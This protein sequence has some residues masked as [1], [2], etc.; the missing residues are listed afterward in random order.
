MLTSTKQ[1]QSSSAETAL[2]GPNQQPG[3][4]R[5]LVALCLLFPALLTAWYTLD[6]S[7]PF[8]DAADHVRVEFQYCDLLRHARPW[9]AHWLKEFLTVNYCYPPSVH[10]FNGALKAIFGSG[11]WVDALSLITF[12]CLLSFSSCATALLTL[13]SRKA[14][15]LTVTL[16]QAYPGVALLSHLKL[17]DYPHLA[18]Y[19]CAMASLLW[20]QRNPSWSRAVMCG[21]ALGIACT[22]KQIA[23]FFLFAPCLVVLVQQL[24]ARRLDQALQLSLSGL[25][26]VLFLAVWVLPNWDGING[27][28]HRNSGHLGDRTVIAAFGQNLAGYLNCAPGL[29][30]YPLLACA[31]LSLFTAK[32]DQLQ[33]LVLPATAALAGTACMCALPFQLP[34]HRYIAP[35]LLFPGLLCS[36]QLCRWFALRSTSRNDLVLCMFGTLLAGIGVL[37]YLVMNFAPYPLALPKTVI[38]AVLMTDNERRGPLEPDFNPTPPG[39]LWGQQWLVRESKKASGNQ[40]CWLNMLPSTPELSVHTLALVGRYEGS[41]VQ[42]TTSRLWTPTGDKVDFDENSWKNFHFYLV[43]TGAQGLQFESPQS[44]RNYRRIEELLADQT[45]YKLVATRTIADGST[46]RLYGKTDF[47]QGS[48]R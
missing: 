24:R 15:A 37:Q 18:L 7:W 31:L 35:A 39:D 11:R 19:T 8:W 41:K 23:A 9:N 14:A 6:N 47:V 20:W 21:T 42:F 17:L 16:L 45:E 48:A 1:Q 2:S 32:K 12:C 43:K 44:A 4:N 3:F 33:A 25:M 27:Y 46:L 26:V 28:M 5:W 38:H 36:A 30:G 29:T 34:E 10:I 22:T 40:A 13:K